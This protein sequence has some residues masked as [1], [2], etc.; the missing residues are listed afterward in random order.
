MGWGALRAIVALFILPRDEK[1]SVDRFRKVLVGTFQLVSQADWEG[2][3]GRTAV[4][5]TLDVSPVDRKRHET[6]AGS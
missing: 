1:P 6:L 4:A 5:I 3:N 2:S